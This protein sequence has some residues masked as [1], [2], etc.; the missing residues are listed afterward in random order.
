[1]EE[2]GVGGQTTKAHLAGIIRPRVAGILGMVRERLDKAGIARYAGEHVVLTG[3]ASSLVGLG[4]F[5]ANTLG[6]PVRVARPQ[7]SSGL[8]QS[9]CTPAFS[10]AAGLLAVAASGGNEGSALRDRDAFTGG[11]LERVGEWLKTGF[12]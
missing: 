5:A 7:P 10:T 8:P 2:D 3:G 11:Y 12:A 4:E 9:F 1:G 6:R